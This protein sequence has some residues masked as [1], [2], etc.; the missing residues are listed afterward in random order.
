MGGSFGGVSSC[1]Y[2]FIV[3]LFLVGVQVFLCGGGLG[4]RGANPYCVAYMGRGCL[5]VFRRGKAESRCSRL[6]FRV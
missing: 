4:G 5:S 1:V 2:F 6:M 3:A